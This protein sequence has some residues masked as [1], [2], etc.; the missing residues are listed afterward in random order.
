M[1]D[2]LQDPFKLIF[3]ALFL[4]VLEDFVL[5]KV[6]HLGDLKQKVTWKPYGE[7]YKYDYIV[8]LI[9][10]GFSWSFM[11]HLPMFIMNFN[12]VI[13]SIL[14]N[15]AIHSYVDHLK[16]NDFKL[17]LIQDQIMH[18]IQIVGSMLILLYLV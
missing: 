4:H 7:K 5:Q 1:L 10:H 9:W 14:I 6:G 17:N 8:A 13:P 15:A 16:A 3:L 18:L 12:Y 2:F 11:V